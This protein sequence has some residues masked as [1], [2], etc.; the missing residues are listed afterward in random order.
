MITPA[1]AVLAAAA[2]YTDIPSIV[3]QG[4][5][6]PVK[7]TLTPANGGVIVAFEGTIDRDG[8]ELDFDALIKFQP[9]T[10][11]LGHA[12]FMDGAEDVV[13]QISRQIGDRYSFIVGH[14]LGAALALETAALLAARG[15]APDRVFLFA[16]PRVFLMRLPDVLKDVGIAAYWYG[17]DPVPAVPPGWFQVQCN[18][19]GKPMWPPQA[20]HHITNYV[21]AVTGTALA[22]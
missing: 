19:I 4:R 10:H 17:N 20:A 2:T 15:Q 7:A 3:G 1:Q 16:P 11:E 21:A 9:A 8:W 12:G 6:R 22:A 18:L 13:D 5:F 14:S